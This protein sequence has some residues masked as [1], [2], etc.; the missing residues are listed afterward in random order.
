MS[1]EKKK[2]GEQSKDVVMLFCLFPLAS[3]STSILDDNYSFNFSTFWAS[4]QIERTP[5]KPES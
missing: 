5:S 1:R 3:F 4:N 2:K